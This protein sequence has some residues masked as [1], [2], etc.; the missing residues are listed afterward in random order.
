VFLTEFLDLSQDQMLVLL[1]CYVVLRS[2]AG[3]KNIMLLNS[4]PKLPEHKQLFQTT[5]FFT[6]RLHILLLGTKRRSASG[7]HMRDSAQGGLEWIALGKTSAR[8]KT[9]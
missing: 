8:S 9:A 7:G 2:P 4:F 5:G 3:K 1:V 6:N